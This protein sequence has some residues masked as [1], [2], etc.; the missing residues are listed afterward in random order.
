MVIVI[1]QRSISIAAKLG[2]EYSLICVKDLYKDGH[3]RKDD[4]A[5]A[6]RGHY[7][8]VDATAFKKWQVER[9]RQGI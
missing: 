7:A 8:S 2:Y 1:G 3:V 9:E 6:L 5:A 4:F